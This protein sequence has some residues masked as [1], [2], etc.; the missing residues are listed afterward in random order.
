MTKLFGVAVQLT[1]MW[2]A[3]LVELRLA[4]AG[5]LNQAWASDSSHSKHETYKIPVNL[6]TCLPNPKKKQLV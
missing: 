5:G 2:P 3:G 4:V 6:K 1:I